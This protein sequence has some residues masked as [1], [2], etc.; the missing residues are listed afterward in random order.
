MPGC[1]P[2]PRPGTTANWIGLAVGDQRPARA[3]HCPAMDPSA[4]FEEIRFVPIVKAYPALSRT[5]GEVCCVAGVQIGDGERPAWIRLYPVPFRS[6]ADDKQFRKY[7]PMD[8]QVQAHGGDRR[9]ETRRPNVDS[10]RPSGRVIGT[11]RGW[12]ARR[13]LVEPLME[14]SMCAIQRQQREVGKSLAVFRPREVIDLLIEPVEERP[15]KRRMAAA[16]AAQK[17]LFEE[18]EIRALEQVPFAFKYRYVCADPSCRTHTQTIIDWEIAQYYRRI[19]GAADWQ[20]RLRSR[21][22]GELCGSG[23]DTAFIV[24]NQHQ[25]PMSFLVLGVW[26]PPLAP[27]QLALGEGAHV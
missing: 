27:E 25:H 23:K 1:H 12:R 7:E 18:A 17:S 3:P 13:P 6:L 21:W 2:Q 8:I 4:A 16:A 20:D 5:Y 26:W 9:L 14:T 22:L 11:E 10:I 15:D 24:G 19:R